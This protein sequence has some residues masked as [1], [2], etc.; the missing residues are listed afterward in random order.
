MPNDQKPSA[1]DI[2][3]RLSE[4]LEYRKLNKGELASQI[5]MRPGSVG[6]ILAGAQ[7]P[8]AETLTLICQKLRV[9]PSYIMLGL[10]PKYLEDSATGLAP[11]DAPLPPPRTGIDQWLLANAASVTDDERAWMRA[12]PWP[13][14]HLRQTDLVYWTVL[15]AY[16]EARTAQPPR[17]ISPSAVLPDNRPR[18]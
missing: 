16:R 17:D 6:A 13:Q 9:H 14:P 5:G 15:S 18:P 10:E 11:V 4:A 2:P 8:S 12:V 3:S 7:Q 1:D